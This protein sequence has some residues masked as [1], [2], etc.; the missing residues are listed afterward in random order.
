[1]RRLVM[2]L[3][4]CA[5]LWF[6]TACAT[7]FPVGTLYTELKLPVTATSAY[8]GKS[9][10]VGTAECTSVLT[11]VTTGDASIE[12]AMKNGGIRKIHHVD[13]EVQNIL[14][15]IGKYKVVVYGE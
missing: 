13:W 4:A 15:V 11:L 10:K 1:M 5:S 2:V 14:G 8:S 7:S 9:E 12:T 3:I 6:L